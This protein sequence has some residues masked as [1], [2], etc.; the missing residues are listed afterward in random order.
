MNTS[1]SIYG[2]L[3]AMALMATPALSMAQGAK[4]GA[5]RTSEVVLQSPQFKAASEK[6][7]AEFER[8]RNEL[9]A[10]AK[11]F[12]ED[13]EKFQKE[14]DLLS[15]ADR[16]KQEKELN[17][18]RIDIGYQQRQLQED[19]QNRDRELTQEMQGKIAQVIED[20]AKAGGFD[21]V[22]QDPAY[23]SDAVNLTDE[24]IAKLKTLK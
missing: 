13:A 16:A 10:S 8:R 20:V 12:Q 22:V 11:K 1:K 3:L 2:S 14:A 24:V 5:I 6:M 15:A 7:K 21:L 23:A 4:I 19:V 9:E 17:T 18:R